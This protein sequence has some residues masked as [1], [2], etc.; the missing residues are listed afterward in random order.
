M[1]NL[2]KQLQIYSENICKHHLHPVYSN[3]RQIQPKSET[4][5]VRLN[6][7]NCYYVFLGFHQLML[8]HAIIPM[9]HKIGLLSI[10]YSLQYM[11]WLLYI[12]ILVLLWRLMKHISHYLD[13]FF[14]W[15]SVL[16]R[17]D[18]ELIIDIHCS[19]TTDYLVT[20]PPLPAS[21]EHFRGRRPVYLQHFRGRPAP[22]QTRPDL[23]I[24]IV[25]QNT[26]KKTIEYG[27]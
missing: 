23:G 1:F 25:P 11:Y 5:Y 12:T 9:N 18:I 7:T 4:Q 15:R 2:Q 22:K 17:Y 20:F 10:K 14:W 24:P 26:W 3:P 6:N 19:L 8:F 16:I 13:L 27:W 21:D